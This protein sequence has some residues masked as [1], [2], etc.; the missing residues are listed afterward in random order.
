MKVLG[1]ERA[2]VNK[3]KDFKSMIPDE[4]WN[5]TNAVPIYGGWDVNIQIR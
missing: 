4:K 1:K 5:I 3:L 2:V